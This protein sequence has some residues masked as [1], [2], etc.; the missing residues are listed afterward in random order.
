M[1][2]CIGTGFSLAK[3]R[4]VICDECLSTNVVIAP[5]KQLKQKE[6]GISRRGQGETFM[7]E[8]QHRLKQPVGCDRIGET[9]F[10]NASDCGINR[11]AIRAVQQFQVFFGKT[12]T[13]DNLTGCAEVMP[14]DF[15][16]IIG[17][18]PANMR[19][20]ISHS[21]LGFSH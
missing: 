21:H 18:D 3:R 11:S 17:I 5:K 6:I 14:I 4:L 1:L 16:K 15:G 7:Y 19:D 8:S 12:L 2:H 20:R 9:S 10:A 13:D